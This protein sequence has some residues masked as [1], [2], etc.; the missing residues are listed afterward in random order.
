MRIANLETQHTSHVTH[1]NDSSS[2][3]YRGTGPVPFARQQS[4]AEIGDEL[5]I[6]PVRLAQRRLEGEPEPPRQAH[7]GRIVLRGRNCHAMEATRRKGEVKREMQRVRADPT[8]LQAG[9]Q[10]NSDLALR[11]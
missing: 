8:A 4:E 6:D 1:A 10:M 2:R 11:A 3:C 5:T 7:H 9:Q